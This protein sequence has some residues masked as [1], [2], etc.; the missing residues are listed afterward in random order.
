[1][2]DKII[3]TLLLNNSVTQ[4]EILDIYLQ[5][6][7]EYERKLL[8]M[9]NRLSNTFSLTYEDDYTLAKKGGELV[10]CFRKYYTEEP[11]CI[12]VSHASNINEYTV[13]Y[14]DGNSVTLIN[15]IPVE[16]LIKEF[17][18]H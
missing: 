5:S 1:M 4:S 6:T 2:I 7:D 16:R 13:T 10:V 18:E 11:T 12:S 9:I 8:S 3:E 14:E 17:Y 15:P